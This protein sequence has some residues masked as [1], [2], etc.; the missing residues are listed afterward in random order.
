MSAKRSETLTAADLSLTLAL[1][2]ARTLAGAAEAL[3]VDVS[4]IFRRLNHLERRL[5][6]RLFDRSPH[7]YQ[8]TTAGE[9]ATA[10]AERVET[11][12]LA[13][14]REITGRDQ[15]LTGS[16]RITASETLSFG[17]LPALLALFRAS[18][19]GIQLTLTIENRVLDLG[20]R[21]ADVALRTRRPTQGDLFG[22]RLAGIAWAFY[23]GA[24][25]RGTLK[26]NGT[27]F[28]FARQS[29]IGWDDPAA[30]IVEIGRAHV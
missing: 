24:S 26:R 6:V 27:T 5:R 12:L 7:G 23:D 22:R 9:R 19:P 3:G 20:R 30:R 21:E 15:Q 8:L 28:D 14:D 2:R 13:L 10:T 25:A 1:A 17:V 18:H 11:E 16:L 4:T 29:V